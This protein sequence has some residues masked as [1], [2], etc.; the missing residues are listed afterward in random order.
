M[1]SLSV[2]FPRKEY[3]SGL[4]FLS[5]EDLSH[6]GIELRSPAAQANSVPPEPP[7]KPQD[8]SGRT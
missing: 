5:L 6:P 2:G 8:T 7:G 1:A 4:P 3:W